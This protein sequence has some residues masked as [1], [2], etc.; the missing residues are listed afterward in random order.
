MVKRQYSMSNF[1]CHSAATPLGPKA[2]LAFHDASRS[3]DATDAP[4]GL[5]ARR[6][7]AAFGNESE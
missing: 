3:W 2:E 5:G 4:T 1:L 7:S 6:A